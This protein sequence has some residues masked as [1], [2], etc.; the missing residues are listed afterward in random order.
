[1]GKVFK[2]I[3]VLM[4]LFT[5]ASLLSTPP[6]NNTA[7]QS[8]DSHVSLQQASDASNTASGSTESNKT[9]A[10]PPDTDKSDVTTDAKKAEDSIQETRSINDPD[11]VDEEETEASHASEETAP[12]SEIISF[13]TTIQNELDDVLMMDHEVVYNEYYKTLSIKLSEDNPFSGNFLRKTLSLDTLAIMEIA[14]KYP[15]GVSEVTVT[16]WTPMVGSDGNS[17]TIKV[18]SSHAVM[19]EVSN[20]NWEDL[21]SYSPDKIASVDSNM[22]SVWWHQGLMEE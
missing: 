14:A 13:S 18:Y 15:A 16:G 12:A 17:Q 5:F 22:D 20:V 8:D 21:K 19:S 4:V 11:V 7:P 9:Y 3:L 1:M 6:A 10:A 2:G